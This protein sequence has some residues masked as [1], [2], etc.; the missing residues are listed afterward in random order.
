M[1]K[2][3]WVRFLILSLIIA[4]VAGCSSVSMPKGN[5]KKY[6]SARFINEKKSAEFY[7]SDRSK[8]VNQVLQ[9]AIA[10][11]FE[12]HGMEVLKQDAD[13]IIAYLIIVQD[14]VATTTIDKHFG[15]R[16]TSE[17]I[18]KIHEKGIGGRDPEY[19]KKGALV[20]DLIDAKTMKLVY[21]NYA[22][23]GAG[24]NLTGEALRTRLSDVTEEVLT[25]FFK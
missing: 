19:V 1:Q 17:A 9:Q 13:L 14:K 16:D 4:V 25:A 23:R 21:R 18:G 20:I 15:Y 5:S 8:E 7:E 3:N 12:Q 10:A 2:T 6:S 24:E 11:E 22:T